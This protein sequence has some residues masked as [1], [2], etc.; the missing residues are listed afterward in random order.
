MQ[1]PAERHMVQQIFNILDSTENNA[2]ILNVGAGKSLE[3]EKQLVNLGSRFICDRIDID[4]CQMTF[5]AVRN[6]MIC[7]V[8]NMIP[9][10][11]QEYSIAFANYVLEHVPNIRDASREIFRV[12]RPSGIF[13]TTIPNPI[14]LEITIARHTPFW[15]HKMVR[16]AT[17]WE[18]YY[19]YRNIEE[20]VDIFE[21]AGFIVQ[22]INYWSFIEGYLFRYPFVNIISK[23]YD[24]MVTKM[25]IK[26]LMC[27][28]CI[29]FKKK[30]L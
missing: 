6:C 29:T 22:D 11:S 3:I 28:V 24:Y 12:L 21:D 26:R 30:P 16:Q 15:F 14:S 18:T 2:P 17:A 23:F 10:N 19:S 13:V 20:F 8:E 25:N 1:T 5:P 27:Q 7:S 4:E 9:V